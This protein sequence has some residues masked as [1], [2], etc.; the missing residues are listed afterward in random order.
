MTKSM[1]CMNDANLPFSQMIKSY[2]GNNNAYLVKDF[3]EM[4]LVKS[5]FK[6]NHFKLTNIANDIN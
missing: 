2:I 5:I 3:Y 4:P 1:Q 6:S